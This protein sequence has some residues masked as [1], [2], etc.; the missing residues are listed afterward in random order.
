[1]WMDTYWLLTKTQRQN[2]KGSTSLFNLQTSAKT[3]AMCF[4][5]GLLKNT[6]LKTNKLFPLGLFVL[7]VSVK[8]I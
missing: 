8:D 6:H 4:V 7:E 5:L 3:Q 1:M 2:L